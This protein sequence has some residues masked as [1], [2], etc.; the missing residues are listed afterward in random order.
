MFHTRWG[1]IE[2]VLSQEDTCQELAV[3]I[4]GVVAR[5]IN[6]PPLTGT[7]NPGERVLLNT[8]A[9]E[10]GLGTGGFH[11]VMLREGGEE[12]RT[13]AAGHIMKMRYTPWQVQVDPAES[14]LP[15]GPL[16]LE[17][18]PVVVGELHSQLAP[19]VLG[20]KAAGTGRVVYVMTDGGALPVWFSRQVRML[21]ER[22]LIV[23]VV[24]CGHAF[25][26]D[27]E[28]IDHCGALQVARTKARADVVV[29]AMGPGI[30]GTGTRL[31]W[32]GLEQARVGDSVTALNGRP[33]AVLRI[34]FADPRPRHRG[35]SH[36]SRTTL[37]LLMR[38]AAFVAVPGIGGSREKQIIRQL[39]ESGISLRHR[40]CRIGGSSLGR[41][42]AASDIPLYTMGRSIQEDREYFLAAAA[43][44]W[45][46]G[47]FASRS[48]S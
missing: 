10:L 8:T 17:G 36:H 43:A 6:Y 4:G 37:G 19:I 15:D 41:I 16:D 9:V 23:G 12:R 44:G 7:A 3:R 21:K 26:G 24:T 18:M 35:L 31:G 29:V 13:S 22:G 28:A 46:A 11:F 1:V 5:A 33:V 2:A 25:G 40:L 34:S 30:A 45:L 38:S 20:A 27:W 39:H 32:S 14:L 42:L 47:R 48:A